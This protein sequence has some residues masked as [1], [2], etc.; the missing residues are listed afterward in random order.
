[1]VWRILT[2]GVRERPMLYTN[3]DLARYI[4]RATVGHFVVGVAAV[5]TS[6]LTGWGEPWLLGLAV[7]T[8]SLASQLRSRRSSAGC[9]RTVAWRRTVERLAQ[10]VLLV[11]VTPVVFMLDDFPA[12]VFM[13]MPVLAWGALRSGAYESIAQLFVTLGFAIALTTRGHG[14]FAHVDERYGLPADVQGILLSVFIIDCAL[15]VVPFVLSVGEQLETARQVAAER[16]KVQN[17]VNGTPGSRSSAP[18]AR[19]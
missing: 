3:V 14:P 4:A 10:W 13:L 19:G 15:V 11:T 1:M 7:G 2:S 8:S 5:V 12:M 6:L 17:I 16:D 9:A 18:T